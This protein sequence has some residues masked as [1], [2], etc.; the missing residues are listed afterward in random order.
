MVMT[1]FLQKGCWPVFKPVWHSC[2]L[3]YAQAGL[4]LSNSSATTRSES[5][6]ENWSVMEENDEECCKASENCDNLNEIKFLD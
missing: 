4:Y 3:N 6:W 5:V 2:Q 1:I